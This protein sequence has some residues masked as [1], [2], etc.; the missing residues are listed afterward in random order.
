MSD[1]QHEPDEQTMETLKR[2]GN[3]PQSNLLKDMASEPGS[4]LEEI[5]PGVYQARKDPDNRWST[6]G[7]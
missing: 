6:S 2:L 7:P 4:G 5:A 1:D 3:P